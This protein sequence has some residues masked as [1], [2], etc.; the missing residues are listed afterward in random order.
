MQLRRRF[1][2]KYPVKCFFPARWLV[3]RLTCGHILPVQCSHVGSLSSLYQHGDSGNFPQPW[4]SHLNCLHLPNL[5][6]QIQGVKIVFT[7]HFGISG[8][9]ET[10]RGSCHMSYMVVG[11]FQMWWKISKQSGLF[12]YLSPHLKV[13]NNRSCWIECCPRVLLWS[14]WNQP[15]FHLHVDEK[16]TTEISFLGQ[17]IL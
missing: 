3:G 9:P 1:L 12:T 2:I 5:K 8:L 13:P 7:N 6:S 17:L 10:S 11:D 4:P 15:T 14:T 16:T